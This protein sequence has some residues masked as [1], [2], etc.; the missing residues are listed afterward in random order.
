MNKLLV[1]VTVPVLMFA[2]LVAAGVRLLC[3]TASRF[4][5]YL[6][7]KLRRRDIKTR[8]LFLVLTAGILSFLTL[9][10]L[11]F[12]A[13][14]LVKNGMDELGNRVGKAGARF[15]EELMT[16]HFRETLGEL[17]QARADFINHEAELIVE[18][19]RVL[20][21][22]MTYI[23]SNPEAWRPIRL[24]DPRFDPVE[25]F[26]PYI[27]YSPESY[28]NGTPPE[29]LSPEILRDIGVAAN[30]RTYLRPLSKT[31]GE[32]LSTF[33][34]GSKD[35]WTICINVMPQNPG[36]LPFSKD[37]IY[38][39]DCRK[40]PW[41]TNA[42]NADK[43][44]FS[45]LYSE[46][47]GRRIQ[48]I[49]CSAP[50]FDKNGRAGV[51]GID[52]ANL[53]IYSALDESIVGKNGY[54]FVLDQSGEVIF[55]T[56]DDSIIDIKVEEGLDLR[57]SHEETLAQA[58]RKMVAGETGTQTIVVDDEEYFLAYAPMK[59]I[60]WSFGTLILR[61]D[62]SD[63]A[64][65]GRDYFLEQ[66]KLFDS[67]LQ[68]EFFLLTF[69]ALILWAWLTKVFYSL[70]DNLSTRFVKPIH[71]LS[72]GVREIAS[73]NL[74][75]KL[76]I[77]TGDEI[78]TLADDFNLM[79]NELKTYMANLTKV[80]ADKERL[81]TELDVATEI[82]S[83]MLPKDFPVRDDFEIFATMTPAKEVGGDFYDFYMLDE[84]HVAITVADVSG[85][86]IPAALFMVIAKTILN[87]F[88]VSMNNVY[89][90]SKVVAASNDKLCANNDAMMFVT[91]FV[92]VL[93][94]QTGEFKFVNAGHNPPVIY[95]AAD[96]GCEFL[97]V[98]KNFVLGPM[99]GVPFVEQKISLNAGDLLFVYTDGVTEAMNVDNEEYQT[100]RGLLTFM[101]SADCDCRADLQTLLKNIRVDVAKHVGDAE[102][103]DDI[104][105]FAL[106]FKGSRGHEV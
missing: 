55:S 37:D 99:D 2:C 52:L 67:H 39:Y 102:Q 104:T 74:N 69:A 64:K 49:S 59:S 17:A 61:R 62:I 72:E 20:S 86:G 63:A 43:P 70:S 31:F 40:R 93:D 101:N 6:G 80:T 44:I 50:Y 103:S 27:T 1:L 14:I 13:M 54:N 45:N 19:V 82:Q 71:K 38:N 100:K 36:E 79:T 30:I 85:K 7:G 90:L 47:E 3:K 34:V 57:N 96:N 60:G 18:N 29:N 66:V 35:G 33:Y 73:G 46:V 87:N 28:A 83:G 94:L 48:L 23:A 11:S 22:C 15:T 9:S 16:E 26:S 78:G 53:D 105:M 89:G 8:L 88:A 68:G 95:R 25:N 56:F 41:Y 106:R 76:E 51:V 10:S 65:I 21:R 75:K 32:Y 4:V 58:A 42:I 91:A 98:K 5:E 24:R 84:T 12:Y 92:G 81:A 77:H 97:E